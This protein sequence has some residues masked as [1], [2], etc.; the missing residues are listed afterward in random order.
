MKK[1]KYIAPEV[2]VF[3][4]FPHESLLIA[5][6][7]SGEYEK[8]DEQIDEGNDELPSGVTIHAKGNVGTTAFSDWEQNNH[9]N[10]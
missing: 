2:E 7:V 9:W 10:Q 6:T 3:R 1:K 5:A 4:C 8:N